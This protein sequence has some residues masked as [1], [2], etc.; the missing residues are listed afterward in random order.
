MGTTRAE[1][2]TRPTMA[3]KTGRAQPWS[4]RHHVEQQEG[5]RNRGQDRHGGEVQEEAK[6]TRHPSEARP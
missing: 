5:H 2:A 1:A 3:K 4:D 6:R